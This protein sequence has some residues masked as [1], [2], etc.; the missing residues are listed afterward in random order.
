MLLCKID[1]GQ[2]EGR[3]RID[4]KAA[5]LKTLDDLKAVYEHKHI[6]VST[7]MDAAPMAEMDESLAG[8]L[9]GNLLK[10]AFIH[11]TAGGTISVKTDG[12]TLTIA[13]TGAATKLDDSKIFERFYHSADKKSSTGLG[14]SL[15]KAICNLYGFDLKYSFVDGKHTFSITFSKK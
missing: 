5:T 2:F 3:T 11:N 14:L 13:N 10:N 1:N 9:L 8:I 4:I 12:R 6:T 15:V 7:D